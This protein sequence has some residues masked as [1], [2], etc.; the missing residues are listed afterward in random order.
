MTARQDIDTPR[1]SVLCQ[2][3]IFMPSQQCRVSGVN[4]K[5]NSCDLLRRL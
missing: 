3:C 5:T 1:Y 4:L 2:Q